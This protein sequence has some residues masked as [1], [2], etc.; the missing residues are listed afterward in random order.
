MT[1]EAT[2]VG[3][4]TDEPVIAAEPTLE[5]RFAAAAIDPE[6]EKKPE[7]G[8]ETDAPIVA[9]EPE[10]TEEDVT[11]EAEAELPPITPPVSWTA[12]E[13]EEFKQLPRALQETLTR[14]ESEREKFVQSKAQEA[15]QAESKVHAELSEAFKS[16]A[17]MFAQHIAA[18]RVPMPQK[19]S[20]QVQ[21]EDPYTYAE[22]MD[23][24]DRA[25]AHNH[26]IEQQLAGVSHQIQQAR[27]AD[28]QR[29]QMTTLS[30]LQTEFPE[31]LDDAKGPEIRQK[32]GS[33]AQR[34]GYSAEQIA[35][36]D[37]RDI[38]AMK[39]ATEAFDKADKYDKLMANKMAKVRQAKDMPKVSKPGTAQGAG[40]VQNQ[41]Y[42]ADRE[43]MKRGDRDAT[44]RV[45]GRF[46]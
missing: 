36:A 3:G 20:H 19:P 21:A 38:M 17:S 40:S 14:R 1:Q 29:Q 34:L 24:Y 26:W 23:A 13:K 46:V 5:D 44:A 27:Q 16:T 2:P 39:L 22:Q 12:E 10:L 7:E 8:E 45:F 9:E 35:Q 18:L 4:A 15:K 28:I 11:D 42:T 25:A 30:A 43:A 37:H 33:T 32:L 31:Y 41:R 6:N